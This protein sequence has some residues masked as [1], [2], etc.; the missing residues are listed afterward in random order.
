MAGSSSN[1]TQGLVLIVLGA[2]VLAQVARGGAVNR[3]LGTK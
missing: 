2:L 1:V 3:L